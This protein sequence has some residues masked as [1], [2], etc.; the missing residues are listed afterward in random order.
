MLTIMVG[1]TTS[2]D[3]Q[4]EKFVE[5][6]GEAIQLEHSLVS[7]SKWEAIHEKPFLGQRNQHSGRGV[8]VH[9]VHAFDGKSPGGFSRDFP[10]RTFRRS[11]ATLIVR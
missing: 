9:R 7:L 1:S 10:K 8:L 2:Y 3:E 6:G 11:I 4:E 5:Q